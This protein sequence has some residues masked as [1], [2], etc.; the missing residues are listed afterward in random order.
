MRLKRKYY[1]SSRSYAY[2]FV[3]YDRDMTI[4]PM[5]AMEISQQSEIA[6]DVL[7]ALIVMAKKLEEYDAERTK[8]LQGSSQAE[9]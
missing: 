6:V 7:D 4:V 8:K 3:F 1:G 5:R 2:T 9:S